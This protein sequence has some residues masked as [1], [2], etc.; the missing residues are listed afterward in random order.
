MAFQSMLIV[1]VGATPSYRV[2]EEHIIFTE[3]MD[4]IVTEVNT[5]LPFQLFISSITYIFLILYNI[6]YS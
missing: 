4:S 6:F 3:K 2:E 5:M 1:L